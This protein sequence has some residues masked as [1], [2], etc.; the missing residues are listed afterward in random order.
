M[1][2]TKLSIYAG[3][4]NIQLLIATIE[5]HR[6]GLIKDSDYIIPG[7]RYSDNQN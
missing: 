2:D 3:I 1:N 4:N 7:K 6:M 5:L